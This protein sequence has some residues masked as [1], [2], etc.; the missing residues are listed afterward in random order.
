MNERLQNLYNAYIESG[1]LSKGT[2]FEVFM[3]ADDSVINTLYNQGVDN[4]IISQAT[5]LDLFKSA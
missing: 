3:N 2:S 4:R 5:D 1:L